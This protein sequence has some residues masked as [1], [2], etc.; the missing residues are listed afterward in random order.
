[1]RIERGGIVIDPRDEIPTTSTGEPVPI[2]TTRSSDQNI[3]PISS[4]G[5]AQ[6][7]R[8]IAAVSASI[9]KPSSLSADR[10]GMNLDGASII[11]H[12][13]DH[14]RRPSRTAAPSEGL[15]RNLSPGPSTGFH[16]DDQ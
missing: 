14:G 10:Y 1:L 16:V 8:Y 15:T 12:I 9:T 5:S 13:D 2:P 3:V 11:R 6:V 4:R 7:T